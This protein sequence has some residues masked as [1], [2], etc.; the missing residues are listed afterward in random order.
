M[1][2]KELIKGC[3]DTSKDYIGKNAGSIMC[4]M[5]IGFSL[6]A[7]IDA[8]VTTPKAVKAVQEAKAKKNDPLTKL[9][10]IA[11]AGPKYWRTVLL[12]LTSGALAFGSN[13]YHLRTQ[14]AL[15]TACALSDSNFKEYK[16]KV[17]EIAGE[18]KANLIETEA[19]E[20][21][22]RNDYSEESVIKTGFGDTLFYESACGRYFKSS[23]QEVTRAVID[24]NR[25]MLQGSV[26]LND[27]YYEL[28]IPTTSLGDIFE[29][30][31]E[32]DAEF[33]STEFQATKNDNG[34]PCLM[35]WLDVEDLTRSI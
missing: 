26:S 28:N 5:G 8:V 29:F 25:R 12:E 16:N 20:Q 23:I 6:L 15:I 11:I 2:I 13:K 27:L 19:K 4:Y 31:G 3:V 1:N 35:I 14:A 10:I 32:M 33:L 30:P 21:K 7:T 9:D 22:A 24:I 18:K 34:E 17:L